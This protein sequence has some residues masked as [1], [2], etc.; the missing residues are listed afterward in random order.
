MCLGMSATAAMVGAGTVATL[1]AARRREPAAIWGTLGYFTLMEALQLWG[2]GVRDMCGT[3]SNGA[4]T[5]LSYLHI[6]LQPLVINAFAMAIA[7]RPVPPGARRLA[8]GVAG[9]ASALLLARLLP[10]E[11]L[12]ACLPGTALCSDRLCLTS[13]TW[14]IAW[15][16]PLNG[17][18][19]AFEGWVGGWPSYPEY[20]V[21]VFLLPLVY[22]AWRF[23]AFH[24]VA[25]PLLALA[26]TS[27]PDEMPAVWCLFSIGILLIGLSP[28]IRHGVFTAQ[29]PAPP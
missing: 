26:L 29:R 23:V 17:L 20:F 21:A 22:G 28:T 1:V 12:G 3:P 8:Y 14:H 6:A 24:A 27:D 9:L 19:A 2:Y 16:L 4:V 15:E 10:G 5:V 7:P 18:M 25:G 11:A 13:G